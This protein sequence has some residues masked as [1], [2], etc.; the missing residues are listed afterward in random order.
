VSVLQYIRDHW[1]TLG[2]EV[3]TQL[4]IPLISIA[5]ASIIAIAMGVAG[6]RWHRAD[7]VFTAVNST[8][9]TIPSYAL[10]GILAF[11]TGTGN[12]PVEIGLVLYALLPIQRNTTAGLAGVPSEIVEAARGMGM[13]R[14]QLLTK[15][16]LPLA[17]PV[18]LAGVRQATASLVAITTVGAAYDSDN[19]GR[20]ILEFLRGGSITKLLAVISLLIL[21][22]LAADALL[23]GAQRLLDRGRV[24]MAAA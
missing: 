5:V 12:L 14:R 16:E 3:A 2:T 22:G 19:L 7:T 23:A 8:L 24:A 18:V 20:P 9:L 21:I 6:A 11:V 13:N 1:D 15:V 4:R 10:F 17:L